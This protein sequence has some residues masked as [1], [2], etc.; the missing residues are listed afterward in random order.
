MELQQKIGKE[1]GIAVEGNAPAKEGP[2]G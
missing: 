1:T 2:N